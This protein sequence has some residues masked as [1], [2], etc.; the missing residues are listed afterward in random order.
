MDPAATYN[1]DDLPLLRFAG[2][3]IAGVAAD[4]ERIAAE[5]IKRIRVTYDVRPH[6][7][8]LDEARRADAPVVFEE[9]IE[10]S[11]TGGGG[12]GAKGVSLRG[13]V[14]GPATT[15]FY[16]G[17][18]GDVAKGKEEAD[19]LVTRTFRTQVQTHCPLETHGVVADWT[20]EGL[21][22]W[23]STQETKGVRNDLAELFELPR[24][25][26]R[27]ISEYTGGGFGAK[28]GAGTHGVLATWLSKKTGRPVKLMLNRWEEHVSVGNRP[29]SWQELTIGAKKDG[30]LTVVDQ[31]SYGTAGVG[32][33]AGVGRVAQAMYDCPNF[34]TE[35]YDVIT[36]AGPGAAFRAP[37]NVQ[38]A[39]AVEQVIDELAE[40]LDIDP[41][42]LRE[43]HRPQRDARL[44]TRSR[45]P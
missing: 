5:A 6:V 31:L 14:R 43:P 38:G 2:Q 28:Y 22:V 9:N 36:H 26:V 15:S 41:I 11:E 25:K 18:R 34:K 42:E 44:A 37:G 32:L 23:A 3:P 17:P 19:V 30:T 21:T 27:V 13:N 16:G 24:A 4:N 35:Q 7:V 45:G 10:V 39:F 8:D 20:P 33:G 29:N 12:G 1:P 40:K